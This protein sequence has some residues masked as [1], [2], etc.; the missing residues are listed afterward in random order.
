M[1][2]LR[3]KRAGASPKRN[4][5]RAAARGGVWDNKKGEWIL[6]R[7]TRS[8]VRPTGVALSPERVTRGG[9]PSRSPRRTYRKVGAAGEAS[10]DPTALRQ[11]AG[12]IPDQRHAVKEFFLCLGS[13][14]DRLWP[15]SV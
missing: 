10:V 11:R 14:A 1:M 12:L 8:S 2:H 15:K 9:S 3:R 13:Y 7:K 5:P 6:L 4:R